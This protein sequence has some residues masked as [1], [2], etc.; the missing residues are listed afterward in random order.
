VPLGLG[1]AAGYALAWAWTMLD[2]GEY[3]VALLL[4]LMFWV[5]GIGAGM[6]I[7]KKWPGIIF[8]ALV[9][10]ATGFSG[11]KIWQE[12]G[13]KSWFPL[14]TGPVPTPAPLSASDMETAVK[15]G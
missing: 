7:V 1:G 14:L 12:R 9:I 13:D 3:G 15:K 11:L 4:V 5:L 8:V 2:R 10:V 6:A